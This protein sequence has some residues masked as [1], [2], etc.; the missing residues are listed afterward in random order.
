MSPLA[1]AGAS[2]HPA[3]VDEHSLATA[4]GL[5]PGTPVYMAP[6]MAMGEAVDGRADIYALGCVAYYLLTGQLVFEGETTLQVI[7]KHLQ[8]DPVPP[9]RR[10]NVDIPSGLER[11]VLACLAKKREDRPGAGELARALGAVGLEPWTQD[12]AK[13]WWQEKGRS[14]SGTQPDVTNNTRTKPALDEAAGARAP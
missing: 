12:E 4:A 8:S 7:V 5:T 6:E 1:A 11:L 14:T 13:R 2:R 3:G 10:A 9:S